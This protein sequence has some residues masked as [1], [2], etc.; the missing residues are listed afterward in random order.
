MPNAIRIDFEQPANR[1]ILAY[2]G[3]T[4]AT[5][6]LSPNE[7][8]WYHL[9]THPDLVEHLWMMTVPPMRGAC[10]ID[11]H[12]RPLLVHP[13]SG[14]VYALAGG[15]GTLAMRLPEP[16]LGEAMAIPGYG[17]TLRYPKETLEAAKLGADWAFLPPFD[18]GNPERLQTA[19]AH[20][21]TLARD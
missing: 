18:R 2:L 9:A 21:G 11:G 4:G 6:V 15:T 5:D 17:A 12:A 14:I 1:A 10:S 16:A 13:E 7:A 19:Y 3:V 20:A 8:N